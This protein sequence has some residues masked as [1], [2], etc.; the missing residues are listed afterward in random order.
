MWQVSSLCQSLVLVPLSA[1]LY[2]ES[3]SK[4]FPLMTNKTNISTL[5]FLI[6]I[7]W[8]YYVHVFDSERTYHHKQD[9]L[10][11]GMQQQNEI[12]YFVNFVDNLVF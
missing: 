9:K 8:V 10:I 5:N 12:L 4:N 7:M 11:L 1:R 3:R 2:L 6:L